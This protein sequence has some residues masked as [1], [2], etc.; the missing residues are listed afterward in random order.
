M[1]KCRYSIDGKCTNDDVSNHCDKRTYGSEVMETVRQC[2][3]L[4]EDDMSEESY[5][6]AMDKKDVFRKYCEW[7][8]LLGSWSEKLLNIVE[9]IY[10]IQIGD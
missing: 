2:L 6:M 10:G 7:N 9:E 5:I 4:E 1:K 3:G 8:G